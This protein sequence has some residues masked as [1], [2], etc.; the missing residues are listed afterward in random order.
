MRQTSRIVTGVATVALAVTM[1]ACGTP[2]PP[3][4]E[5][6]NYP[7]TSPAAY[8]EYG[9]VSSIEVIRTEQPAKASGAGAVLGGV[10]GAVLGHQ[11]GGG[12]GRDIA[13]VAGAVGGAVVGNNVE[14]RNKTDVVETYRVSVQVDNGGFRAYDIGSVA[15][16]RVGDRVRIENGQVTRV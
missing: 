16:L 8:V 9:R 5:V 10:A 11:I 12:T 13:T 15:N 14:K 6:V 4:E 1:V 3:A 2:M 7:A